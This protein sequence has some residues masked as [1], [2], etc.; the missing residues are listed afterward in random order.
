M[1][2]KDNKMIDLLFETSW[3]I[4]NKVGGIHTVISTKALNIINEL[5]DNYILIGPDVWRDEVE[6]P[7]FIPDNR[8]FQDWQDKA[9]SEGLRVRTGRW[10]ISGKPIVV[11]VDFTHHFNEKNEIFA[12]LWEQYK[13]DSLSGEW[14]YIEPALFG[15][16][17]GKVVESFTGFYHEYQDIIAQFHEWMTGVGVLYLRQ[18]APWVSTFFTTHATVLGRTIAGNNRPLYS[19]LNDYKPQQVARE[20]NVV[21]KRSLEKTAAHT[22]DVFTTVSEIT[23]K[24]CTAFLGKDVDIVTPNGFEDTFVPGKD[25]FESRRTEAREI[26]IRV[27]QMVTGREIKDDA[28]LVVTS[29]RYEYH[30]KGIDVFIDSLAEVD[31]S[32][33]N[34]RDIVAYVMVPAYHKG[35]RKDI[36]D[37][38]SGLSSDLPSGENILSHGLHDRDN[39]PVINALKI[40]NLNNGKDNKVLTVFVP[41]YLNGNDGVFNKSYYDLLI[42]FDI[43]VF[44][45][46]YEPWGYTPLESLMFSIPTVT[47]TLAGFGL[48]VQNHYP[49]HG[50]GIC[51]VERDDT[52]RDH[53]TKEIASYIK[54]IYELD[55]DHIGEARE[56]AFKISRIA[57]WDKLVKYYFEAYKIALDKSRSRRDEPRELSEILLRKDIV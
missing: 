40:N 15:Y 23:S 44:P 46:Y 27:A 6:N 1:K 45:S 53:T 14:D 31:R 11:L 16:A 42:G 26:L 12:L 13:L 29:G 22:A 25:E 21:A 30:N 51:V 38:L 43:T 49:G 52:N 41:S 39:D 34:K 8:L 7:E 9:A 28:L 35:P 18:N 19:K 3:E 56:E 50:N 20:F 2:M 5:G 10:N 17:A 32:I 24:E 33:D 55:E 48:W 4:C 54:R 37:Y 36:A 57:N 47:T